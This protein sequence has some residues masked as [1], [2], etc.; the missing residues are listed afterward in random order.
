[1][2][3]LDQYKH[4]SPTLSSYQKYEKIQEFS[5]F[6]LRGIKYYDCCTPRDGHNYLIDHIFSFYAYYA[7]PSV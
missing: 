4:R 1:L 6:F 2:I 7:L 3:Y 5:C